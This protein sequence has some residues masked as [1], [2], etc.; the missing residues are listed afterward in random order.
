MIAKINTCEGIHMY[1]KLYKEII[2][3][4]V[5]ENRVKNEEVYYERHHI[6]PEFMFS[7]RKRKG[8]RGHLP[9]NP[10]DPNNIVL[11]T[12]REHLMAH[13]YLYEI[14]KDSR[15]GYSA[16][17]ALQ[18]FFIKATGGHIRQ[19]NLSEV[20]EQFLVEMDHLRKIGND[21][22]SKARSGTMPVKDKDTWEIIGSVSV[23][24]PNVL[25]GQW[26]HHSKGVPS[27]VKPGN[28][29]SQNGMDNNNARPDV[30]VDSIVDV[31]CQLIQENDY[32][33]KN[34]LLKEILATLKNKLNISSNALTRRI[35]STHELISLVNSRLVRLGLEPVK[36]SPYYR[37][38][39]EKKHLSEM[40]ASFAWVTDG[41]T[42]KLM[43][44]TEIEAYLAENTTFRKGRT[45]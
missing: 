13:Y 9:G 32:Y 12:F 27:K 31:I 38:D 43:K 22:V 29:K 8:P 3:A 19:R 10:D 39:E 42:R 40:A 45:L 11:L 28:R 35:K 30:T 15:Y 1:K 37:S 7:D 6:I 17:S 20:D 2:A 4:A 44:K 5:N 21:S 23:D 41:V 25:S 26:V 24:H 18:F 33:G 16:G 36:Y 14:Y 34:I